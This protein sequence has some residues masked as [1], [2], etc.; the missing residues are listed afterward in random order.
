VMHLPNPSPALYFAT[1]ASASV[2]EQK[3]A[4]L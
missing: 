3:R 1:G 2:G 4:A